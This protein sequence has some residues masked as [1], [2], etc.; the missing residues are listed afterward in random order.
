M[1]NLEKLSQIFYLFNDIF[2]NLENPKIDNILKKIGTESFNQ[3]SIYQLITHTIIF[4]FDISKRI[5]NKV[6]PTVVLF[7]LIVYS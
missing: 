7:L 3:I 6:Q 4:R 5:F 1:T 2:V